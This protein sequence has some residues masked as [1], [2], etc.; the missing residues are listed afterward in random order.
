M[1]KKIIF[2]DVDG[3][4][5]NDNGI[6]PASAIMA[7][8]QARKNEH[9][10]FLC[11]GRS[12][13]EL[14]EDILNIGFDG[15]ICAAGGYIEYKG[16]VI[17]H[18][19][20]KEEDAKHVL[21]YFTK[22][23]ID[24][25]F[26]SNSGLFASE[27]LKKHLENILFNDENLSE[28][29]RKEREK[30]TRPFLD[31]LKEGENLLREDINKISFIESKIPFKEIEREFSDRFTVIPCTVPAFGK[32]SGELSI[33]NI[34]KAT[35]IDIL[36]KYLKVDNNETFAYGDGLNDIEMLEYVNIGVAMGNAKEKLKEIADDITGTPDE[37]GIYNSFLKYKII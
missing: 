12:K 11:T 2:L 6:V 37:D 4:L 19:N 5:V 13:A 25:Y 21:D 10:V 16:E 15:M 27:N 24:F 3:T 7:I 35:S 23:N 18:E 33:P 22:N 20:V 29:D 31:A 9:L 34:H 8:K 14:Y 1:S 28:N 17:F 26:E 32:E 36:L 30:G